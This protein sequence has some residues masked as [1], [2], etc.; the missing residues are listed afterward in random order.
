MANVDTLSFGNAVRHLLKDRGIKQVDYAEQLG[1]TSASVSR[2]LADAGGS[3]SLNKA[4]AALKPLGF[5]V[6]IVRQDVDLPE[7]SVLLR[8]VKKAED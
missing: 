2:M 3:P 7:G 1:V 5:T 8:E 4:L 6:A